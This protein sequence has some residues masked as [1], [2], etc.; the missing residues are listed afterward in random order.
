MLD[1]EVHWN[2]GSRVSASTNCTGSPR[3]RNCARPV[4]YEQQSS[5]IEFQDEQHQA[6]SKALA[7]SA[8]EAL[9][10]IDEYSNLKAPSNATNIDSKI[11][12]EICDMKYASAMHFVTKME[13]WF[14]DLEDTGFRTMRK[15]QFIQIV[16]LKLPLPKYG[17]VRKMWLRDPGSTAFIICRS[18]LPRQ[19]SSCQINSYGLVQG[20]G[21]SVTSAGS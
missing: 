14:E 21:T 15:N 13:E 12:N 2:G 7:S 9:V 11:R 4:D 1:K 19:E 18:N 6:N 5:L 20:P 16:A 8:Y 17:E 3:N 10:A